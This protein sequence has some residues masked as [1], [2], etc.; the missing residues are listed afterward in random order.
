MAATANVPIALVPVPV[1][2]GRAVPALIAPAA[3]NR[4]FPAEF[5]KAAESNLCNLRILREFF[6]AFNH[7]PMFLIIL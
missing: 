7:E 2:T 3:N 6:S 4:W 1:K 5:A